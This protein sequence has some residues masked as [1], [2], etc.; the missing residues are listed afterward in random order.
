M[1]TD[2][3]VYAYTLSPYYISMSS[4]RGASQGVEVVDPVASRQVERAQA[5]CV[6]GPSVL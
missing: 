1:Y 3:Y 5:F 6:L 2:C 4:S